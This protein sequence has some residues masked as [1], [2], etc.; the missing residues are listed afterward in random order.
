[1]DFT[2][3]GTSLPIPCLPCRKFLCDQRTKKALYDEPSYRQI[4]WQ[5]RTH[6]TRLFSS[7]FSLMFSRRSGERID[8]ALQS[9]AN[10]YEKASIFP[11]R[12]K[13]RSQ[14]AHGDVSSGQALLQGACITKQLSNWP[15]SPRLPGDG[16][17][18][19]TTPPFGGYLESAERCE[20]VS[21][22]FRQPG[23]NLCR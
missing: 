3:G 8:P 13:N 5:K 12:H 7:L 2:G 1:M 14:N 20:P 15:A 18:R 6:S 19:R 10:P 23:P 9:N 17:N 11:G 16:R 4:C 21:A 22:L